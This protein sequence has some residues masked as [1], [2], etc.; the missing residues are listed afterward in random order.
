M[1]IDMLDRDAIQFRLDLSDVCPSLLIWSQTLMSFELPFQRMPSMNMLFLPFEIEGAEPCKVPF[2]QFV[3]FPY[4]RFRGS[5]NLGAEMI[6]RPSAQATADL[7]RTGLPTHPVST[8]KTDPRVAAHSGLTLKVTGSQPWRRSRLLPLRVRVDRPVKHYSLP[9]LALQEYEFS[10]SHVEC[11]NY[12]FQMP[13]LQ[14]SA[15]PSF[16]QPS[17]RTIR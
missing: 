15:M 5:L 10:L 16:R 4:L 11:A 6:A 2:S 1:S 12:W 13:P 14:R 8:V 7:R 9:R 3:P 17:V